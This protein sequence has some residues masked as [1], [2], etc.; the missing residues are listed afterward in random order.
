ML[1]ARRTRSAND[2]QCYCCYDETRNSIALLVKIAI[3]T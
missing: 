3:G 1:K 2:R